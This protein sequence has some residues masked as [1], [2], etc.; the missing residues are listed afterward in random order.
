MPVFC[1]PAFFLTFSADN[2][3]YTLAMNH[4]RKR[5]HQVLWKYKQKET[6]TTREE[7]LMFKWVA[8][9]DLHLQLFDELSNDDYWDHEVAA[10]KSGNGDPAWNIIGQRLDDIDYHENRTVPLW[11]KYWS[12]AAAV[13]IITC[14]A[15]IYYSYHP[16]N[17]ENKNSGYTSTLSTKEEVLPASVK[18]TLKLGDGSKV[19][20]DEKG[21]KML[22]MERFG[23]FISAGEGSLV[24]KTDLSTKV[25]Q[26]TLTTPMAAQFKVKLPDGTQVWLNA[27]SSITYPTSFQGDTRK[28]ELIGEGYFEVAKMPSKRFIVKV[29][30]SSINVLGTHFNINAYANEGKMVTTLLEGSVLV[31]TINDSVQL[32]PG[33]KAEVVAD[34]SLTVSR[35][36]TDVA[37][38]WTFQ[39]FRFQ[40]APIPDVMREIARWYDIK[41]VIKGK[42]N[43]KFTGLL[44]RDLTLGQILTVLDSSGNY[45]ISV[46]D[47]IVTVVP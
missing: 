18:A 10:L 46:K 6:L 29:G 41:V 30:E 23:M 22:T 25:E 17:E 21:T 39:S 16:K 35:A 3:L 33:Q 12:V 43:D 32:K 4:K 9:S 13:L 28:V 31:K 37:V 8:G 7:T 38:A 34:K 40:D 26:H 2:E 11:R 27:G 47:K 24:Y 14:S 19:A 15:V 36:N 1:R 42:I 45:S 44:P 5:I 20:L